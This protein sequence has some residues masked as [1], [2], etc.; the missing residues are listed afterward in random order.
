MVREDDF[1]IA[2][3]GCGNPN[4]SDDGAGPEAVRRLSAR[5]ACPVGRVR[6]LDAGTDGMAVIF[7]ARGARTLILIDACRSGSEP[8]AVFELN[9][10]TL[11]EPYKHALTLHDFRWDHALYAGRRIFGTAF[12]NDTVVQ[13][14]E[15]KTVEIGLGLSAPVTAAVDFVVNRVE[16]LVRARLA[17]DL[18]E[19]PANNESK[20]GADN[21]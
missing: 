2:V 16:K 15:A 12:P 13:L 21:D 11:E 5:D 4:R 19:I 20:V 9:G 3:I 10:A 14:I 8:G 18:P 1:M 17:S 6:L 7:A